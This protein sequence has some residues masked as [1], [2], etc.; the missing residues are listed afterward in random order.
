[1]PRSRHARAYLASITALSSAAIAAAAGSAEA[2]PVYIPVNATV[3]YFNRYG[4]TAMIH[5][6]KSRTIDVGIRTSFVGYNTT[7]ITTPLGHRQRVARTFYH[8]VLFAGVNFARVP[9]TGISG[10]VLPGIQLLPKGATT[11]SVFTFFGKSWVE[12]FASNRQ[13]KSDLPEIVFSANYWPGGF[14]KQYAL[15]T[16]TDTTTDQLDYGWLELSAQMGPSWGPKVT[17]IA[18]AYDPSGNPLPAGAG[19]PPASPVPEPSSLPLELSGLAALALGATGVRRW[20]AARG[21]PG[22]SPQRI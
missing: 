1:M 16:F 5:L 2:A 8:P 12:M 17:I 20:R 6:T 14:S 11:Q 21:K 18:A 19:A 13:K 9:V 15:F 22:A 4:G 3:G 7:R 10:A